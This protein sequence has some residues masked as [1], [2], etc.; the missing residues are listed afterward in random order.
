MFDDN[1]LA[2]ARALVVAAG[3]RAIARL[4]EARARPNGIDTDTIDEHG[5]RRGGRGRR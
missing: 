3:P 2:L 5:A 4:C 1:D